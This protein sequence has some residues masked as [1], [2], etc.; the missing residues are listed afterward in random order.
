MAQA[1]HLAEGE[2]EPQVEVKAPPV[3]AVEKMDA[4]MFFSL[5]AE[6]T[7]TNPPHVNG[8]PVLDRMRR[9]A[10]FRASPSASRNSRLK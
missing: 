7:K 9:I 1:I 6:L 3:V 10:S 2:S 4:A 5:F 8:Y